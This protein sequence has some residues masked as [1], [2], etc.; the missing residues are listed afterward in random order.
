[1]QTEDGRMSQKHGL[2]D[3]PIEDRYHRKMNALAKTLD[4]W[5]NGNAKGKHRKVGFCLMVFEFGE[6]P[7]RANYISNASRE[8]VVTLMKEQLA[9]FEGQAEPKEGDA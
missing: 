7:G 9:R 2:G 1:M 8:H 3:A 4:E 5:F 6:G